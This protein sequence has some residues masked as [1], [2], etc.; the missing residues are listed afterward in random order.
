MAPEVFAAGRARDDYNRNTIVREDVLNNNVLKTKISYDTAAFL[1]F[2][3]EHYNNCR[4]PFLRRVI[5]TDNIDGPKTDRRAE[6]LGQYPYGFFSIFVLTLY[7]RV[8]TQYNRVVRFARENGLDA[9]NIRKY[10]V[11][12]VFY[13]KRISVGNKLDENVLPGPR[14]IVRKFIF[15]NNNAMPIAIFRRYFS[16]IAGRTHAFRLKY[17]LKMYFQLNMWVES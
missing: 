11:R 5:E 8:Y 13:S 15:Q 10:Y 9:L 1:L 2:S 14:V 12:N 6:Y 7:K 17:F 3:R 16:G 4:Q